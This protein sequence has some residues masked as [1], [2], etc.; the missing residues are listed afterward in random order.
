MLIGKVRCSINLKTTDPVFFGFKIPRRNSPIIV[1]LH[2]TT[3]SLNFVKLT[4]F[5]LSAGLTE[6][7]ETN[8]FRVC[9][10]LRCRF[11]FNCRYYK[12]C[13]VLL[14]KI[15][16]YFVYDIVIDTISLI[17]NVFLELLTSLWLVYKV[18]GYFILYQNDFVDNLSHWA[19]FLITLTNLK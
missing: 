19:F 1:S 2:C 5:I 16:I 6:H 7:I 14:S 8:Q 12:D 17:L 9:C 15:T 10:L 4:T 18:S 13:N 11:R 3:S